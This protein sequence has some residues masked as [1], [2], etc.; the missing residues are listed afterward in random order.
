V[1]GTADGAGRHAHG[2]DA[3]ADARWL[4]GALALILAFMAGEVIAG[5]AAHSLAL[6]S[7][8]AHMLTDAASIALVLVTAR[9]AARP[10]A[11]GYTYGLKRAE[12]LSAQANGITLVLLAAWLGYT[13]IRH[14]VTPPAVAGGVVLAVALAGMVVNMAATLLIMRAGGGRGAQRSLNLAG[15]FKHIVT[16][17]Y[18]FAATAVAGVVI[19]LTGFDR[20]DAIATLVVVALMVHAGA[21]LI[22]DSGRIFLEAAPAG[23]DPAAVGAAMARRRH[24]TEVHDLH[25]WEITAGL[26]A[27][28]AHVLVAPGEDCHAVRVDLEEFLS[29]EYGI[30]HAT[31]QVD[32][33]GLPTAPGL[34]QVSREEHCDDT[35]GPAYRPGAGGRAEAG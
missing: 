4:S 13:A 2:P 28:S 27:A 3:G 21:G 35:H 24:V 30:T 29:R 1:T 23:L 5:V 32:H 12:I 7:D 9:L 11:G 22:R 31:L 17:L 6:I 14:L 16:D 8:A 15:A 25:I 34:I 26:P 33:A 18:A 19:L 10:P 20:A